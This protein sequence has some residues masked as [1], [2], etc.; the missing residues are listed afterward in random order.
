MEK[1]W[2]S[3]KWTSDETNLFCEIFADP[4][5][6]FMETLERGALKRHSARKYLIPLLLNLK[7]MFSSKKKSQKILKQKKRKKPNWWSKS[8]RLLKKP[9]NMK[10]K[11]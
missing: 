3:L 6:Y 1:Q 7:K 10:S 8:K 5:K 11:V 4:V 2:P 9:C